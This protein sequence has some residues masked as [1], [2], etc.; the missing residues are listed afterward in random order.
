MKKSEI[1]ELANGRCR[2]GHTYL[3]HYQCYLDEHPEKKVKIGFLDIETSNLDANFGVMLTWAIKTNDGYLISDALHKSDLENCEPDKIDTRIVKNLVEEIQQYD[4]IVTYY[5]KRFDVPFLRTR[6]LVDGVEFPAYGSL[7]HIDV[8]FWAKFKLKLNS[9]R[10]DTVARTLFGSTEKNHIEF[11]Y[12]IAGTRG[13][14]EA[15][16][17]ILDHN[18]RDV[19]ELERVYYKLENFAR[20]QDSSI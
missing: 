19:E 17:Y 16:D 5:G 12:W 10:L 1:I 15:I 14:E 6:A 18:Q 8:Y 3:E 2:H 11:K 7:K 9:N 13:D 20:R 4:T